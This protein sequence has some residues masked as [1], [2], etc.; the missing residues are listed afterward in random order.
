LKFKSSERP[1]VCAFPRLPLSSALKRSI[2]ILL[3]AHTREEELR[4]GRGAYT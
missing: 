2:G 1:S 3:S 4:T